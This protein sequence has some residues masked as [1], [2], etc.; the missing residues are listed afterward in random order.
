MKYNVKLGNMYIKYIYLDNDLYTNNFIKE[1]EFDISQERALK[2]K[3]ED[4]DYIVEILEEVFKQ[5]YNLR[6]YITFEEVKE[7]E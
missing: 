7:N 5:E 4:K 1:I 2:I 6:N 3:E